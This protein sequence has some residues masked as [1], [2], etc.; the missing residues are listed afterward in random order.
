MRVTDD[1]VFVGDYVTFTVY[2]QSLLSALLRFAIAGG[3]CN[4]KERLR[5]LKKGAP[6][7]R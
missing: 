4:T 2:P 7:P 3:S 6:L 1:R 5:P